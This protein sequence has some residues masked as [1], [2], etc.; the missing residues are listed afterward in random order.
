MCRAS[1][2]HGR[3]ETCIRSLW[4]RNWSKETTRKEDNTKIDLKQTRCMDMDWINLVEDGV[5]WW[6]VVNTAINLRVPC[7][8]VHFFISWATIRSS[9]RALPHEVSYLCSLMIPASCPM[10]NEYYFLTGRSAF[11]W[12]YSFNL[13]CFTHTFTIKYSWVVLSH[14]DKLSSCSFS[15][16]QTRAGNGTCFSDTRRYTNTLQKAVL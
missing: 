15:E 9:R 4:R 14:R 10:A 12:S 1:R 13:L 11:T 2:M 5:Q 16:I 6:T 8:A 3:D 7:R